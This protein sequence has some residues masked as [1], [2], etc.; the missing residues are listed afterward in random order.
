[1][2]FLLM[3][4]LCCGTGV[5]AAPESITV[6]ETRVS[7]NRR[8]SET[9]VANTFG[10]LQGENYAYEVVRNGL[11]RIYEMGFF[12]EVSLLAEEMPQGHVLTIQ[13]WERPAV[14]AIRVSGNRKIDRG[15]ITKQAVLAV[16]SSLEER[17][18]FESVAAID[19]LYKDK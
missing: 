9:A 6:V 13:V 4:A 2:L 15:D 10:L 8:V 1:M 16:G 18:V 19:S 17:L 12:D 14:G 3:C 11:R 7:G 5:L